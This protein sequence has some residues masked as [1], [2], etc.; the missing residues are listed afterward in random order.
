MKA[1][2]NF[3]DYT[4]R[5]GWIKNKPGLRMRLLMLSTLF[6]QKEQR[7]SRK[8][9]NSSY[10]KDTKNLNFKIYFW[11]L[12]V[13]VVKDV[14]RRFLEKG[15]RFHILSHLFYCFNK[16]DRTYVLISLTSYSS[17]LHN[18]LLQEGRNTCHL[19]DLKHR[20]LQNTNLH[21]LFHLQG[22]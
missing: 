16:F 5:L 4:G 6:Y 1:G 10:Q 17:Y 22:I 18:R 14:L 11:C 21:F 8:P 12:C 3:Q 19:K 13:I 2:R 9:A 15:E 7:H 20:I